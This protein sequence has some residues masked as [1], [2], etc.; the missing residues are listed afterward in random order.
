[1]NWNYHHEWSSTSPYAV[2]YQVLVEAW[3][4]FS[5]EK[6][7][8]WIFAPGNSMGTFHTHALLEVLQGLTLWLWYDPWRPGVSLI[9][10]PIGSYQVCPVLIPKSFPINMPPINKNLL[11]REFI[12][13][14]IS[15]KKKWGLFK[16]LQAGVDP[17]KV[18]SQWSASKIWKL[19]FIFT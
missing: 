9:T 6:N 17:S 12:L 10:K 1:M 4:V 13:F 3:V 14:S 8:T 5:R 7:M 15:Q 18:A 19:A 11:T 16:V 2:S